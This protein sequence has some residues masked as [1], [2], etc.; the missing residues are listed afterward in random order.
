LTTGLVTAA[1]A[2]GKNVVSIASALEDVA[3]TVE[4]YKRADSWQG[5]VTV[6]GIELDSRA[7]S[8]RR[9]LCRSGN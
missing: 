1:A 8:S 7:F 2:K 9:P 4:I 3:H 6:D 5:I